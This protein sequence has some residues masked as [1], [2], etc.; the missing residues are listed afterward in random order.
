MPFGDTATWTIQVTSGG[1]ALAEAGWT[2][3]LGHHTEDSEGQSAKID[4]FA[5]VTTDVNGT[6]TYT[7]PSTTASNWQDEEVR[8]LFRRIRFVW[9]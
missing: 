3:K 1:V 8:V 9:E 7:D 2:F 4:P 5:T 6:A